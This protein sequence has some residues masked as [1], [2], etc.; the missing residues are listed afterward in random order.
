MTKRS[1]FR[2]VLREFLHPFQGAA[3]RAHL[4]RWSK[5][6]N[7]EDVWRRLVKDRGLSPDTSE[8]WSYR[9]AY[10]LIR[11]V[12]AVRREVDAEE[13]HDVS[14][15]ATFSE[16]DEIV[17]FIRQIAR[18]PG[19]TPVKNPEVWRLMANSLRAVAEMC[20]S[21]IPL[22]VMPPSKRGK[23]QPRQR[24]SARLSEH[25]HGLTRKWADGEVAVLTEI[26]YPGEEV[27][28]EMVRAARRKLRGKLTP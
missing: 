22:T 25:L 15:R 4:E 27:S 2:F 21:Q 8:E 3:D 12:L 6:P 7:A 28:A 5:D 14:K 13:R 19:A 17:R 9:S 26:A 20:L 11:Y 24:F 18:V 16:Q 23:T 10:Y 1:D